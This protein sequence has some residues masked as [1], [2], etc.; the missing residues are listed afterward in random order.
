ME[1]YGRKLNV[2]KLPVKLW[3]FC[4]MNYETMTKF[5]NPLSLINAYL[6][7]SAP[8]GNSYKLRNGLSIFLSENLH[9]SITVMVIFCRKEYGNVNKGDVVIDIG[10]NIGIFSLYAA[11]S[12]AKK[13][14]AFEP[15]LSS[16]NILCKN[17]KENGLQDIIFPFNLGVSDVDGQMIYLPK[18]S[19]P[20][21]VGSN[22]SDT[23]Q[24]LAVETLSLTSIINKH[25]VGDVDFCKIDCEG[26]EYSIL[27][28]TNDSTFDRIKQI[29]MEHHR[30]SEKENLIAYLGKKGFKVIG[31]HNMILWFNK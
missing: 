12:G 4:K 29:R 18:E 1:I 9:D 5:R 13:V 17:I 25:I 27:Y 2:K 23:E 21:N 24:M 19:S 10:A 26:A 14:L 22:S 31:E 30:K 11:N 7:L 3:D 16:Y 8:N 15:N 6:R 20:Y 28:T